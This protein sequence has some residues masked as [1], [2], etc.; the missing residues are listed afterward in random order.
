MSLKII[1]SVWCFIFVSFTLFWSPHSKIAWENRNETL[2]V[3]YA[4]LTTKTDWLKSQDWKTSTTK[5][6]DHKRWSLWG[7]KYWM[8]PEKTCIKSTNTHTQRAR[9]YDKD[10]DGKSYNFRCIIR[11]FLVII[12]L[13]FFLLFSHLHLPATKDDHIIFGWWWPKWMRCFSSIDKRTWY[14]NTDWCEGIPENLCIS[15]AQHTHTNTHTQAYW[16]IYVRNLREK[17]IFIQT[18]SR[19]EYEH[20]N[21]IIKE[22][23]KF[24]WMEEKKRTKTKLW[25]KKA[26][27]K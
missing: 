23:T 6:N 16:F 17:M 10:Y 21:A 9:G 26:I 3:F 4:A 8:Q 7:S 22:S 24:Y 1:D 20:K 15:S 14:R 19:W 13:V 27:I 25:K 12:C 5:K 2:F 11:T 18:Q